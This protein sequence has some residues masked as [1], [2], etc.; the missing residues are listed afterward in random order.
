MKI[1]IGSK[2]I[3]GPFGGGNE[4]IRNLKIFFEDRNYQVVDN[5]LD[6]DID[7]I[8]ITNPFLDSETSTFN[9]YDVDYYINFKNPNAIVFQR[10][11]EC[12]ERKGT[13]N[14]NS[15]LNYLNKNVDVNIY[16]SEWINDVYKNFEMSSKKSYVIKGGPNNKIFNSNNKSL[17][18]KKKKIRLVT[19]HWSNN[20]MKGYLDYQYIDSLLGQ[21]FDNEFDFTII[22]NVPENLKF[23]HSTILN[24]LSGLDLSTELKKHDVYLT[25]SRNEPSGNHHMEGAL[26]GLPVMY[27]DS[28]ALPEYCENF[29]VLYNIDNFIDKL[30]EVKSNYENL[31]KNLK[32]YPYNFNNAAEN[33]EKIFLESIKNKKSIL[34]KRYK[35][36]KFKIVFFLFVNKLQQFSYKKLVKAKI[37]LGSLKKKGK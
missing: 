11:N 2:I 6:K 29:G 7:I 4:F 3:K 37:F 8:L 19:H 28:G 14:L 36:N 13:K 10:I 9:N 23:K 30:R 18:D 32:N 21:G 22:G 1:S 24:P 33:Y 31:T 34:K 27:I 25:A 26:C 5:L 12:D 20:L 16:V 15:K 35:N 17:W